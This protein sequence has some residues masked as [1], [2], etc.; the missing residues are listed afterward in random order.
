MVLIKRERE[1]TMKNLVH[2]LIH[3]TPKVNVLNV[4]IKS[5]MCA[6]DVDWR[7][8]GSQIY[9]NRK[10]GEQSSL[11]HRNDENVCVQT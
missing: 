11:E 3:V 9:P 6:S 8:T 5:Q 4:T 2:L 10:F 1:R 7:I